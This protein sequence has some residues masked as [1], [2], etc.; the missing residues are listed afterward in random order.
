MIREAIPRAE[1]VGFDDAKFLALRSL[2]DVCIARGDLEGAER[3]AREALAFG[4]SIHAGTIFAAETSLG[5]ILHLRDR[6][7]EALAVL[8]KAASRG[9]SFF[10]GYPEGL[11]ALGMTVAGMDGAAD[12]CNAAMKFLPRPG[13]TRGLGAWYAVLSVIQA[14]CLGGRREEAGRLQAEAEKIASEWD[15]NHCG[16][17]VRSAAGIAAACAGN[18]TRAEEHHRAA[19][20][21]MEVVPYVTAQPI[22]RYWYADMLAERAG[23][24]DIEAAKILLRETITASDAIGLALYARLARQRLARMS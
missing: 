21:R 18:W 12:A 16:F 7:A 20:A 8:S 2:A 5:G 10:S 24:G 6:T 19:V 9:P 13:H 15:S 1:R 4:A 23:A 14:L 3:T 22:A 17:P 11:L